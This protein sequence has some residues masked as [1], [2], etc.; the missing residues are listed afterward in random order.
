[1]PAANRHT[2]EVRRPTG[3]ADPNEMLIVFDGVF[4][5]WDPATAAATLPFNTVQQMNIGNN[6]PIHLHMYNMQIIAGC[7]PDYLVGEFYDVITATAQPCT[8]R[9][10][11]SDIGGRVVTHCHILR[12]EDAG[13]MTWFNVPNAPSPGDVTNGPGLC[14]LPVRYFVVFVSRLRCQVLLTPWP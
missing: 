7:G 13:A 5:P 12:H 1:M 2:I 8:V 11:I 4:K 9:F 10:L 6:H 14:P 3:S